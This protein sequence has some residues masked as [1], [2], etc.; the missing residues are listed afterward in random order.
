MSTAQHTFALPTGI[1][2]TS[3]DLERKLLA[4][5]Q[6]DVEGLVRTL[7]QLFLLYKGM[8][9]N[10]LSA[11]VLELILHYCEG[12][13]RQAYCYLILG[14]LTEKD[15]KYTAAIDRYAHALELKP[16][17]KKILYFLHN[18][19]AYCLNVL[20]RYEEAE[21]Y[22]RTAIEIDGGMANA[23]KNLGV[24]MAGQKKMTEAFRA[25][26]DALRRTYESDPVENPYGRFPRPPQSLL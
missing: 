6:Q 25:H 13:E 1:P 5:V 7:W 15:Q 18:N 23:Y 20:A 4:R 19:T 12:P 26:I 8:D 10:D 16:T 9:R 21:R 3:R 2:A 14:Q 24:S 17:D 22:C 11:G